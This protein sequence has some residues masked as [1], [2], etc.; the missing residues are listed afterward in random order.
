METLSKGEGGLRLP[1]PFCQS[2]I[3]APDNAETWPNPVMCIFLLANDVV[4][5]LHEGE[6]K[7]HTSTLTRT[8]RF[9]LSYQNGKGFAHDRKM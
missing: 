7:W 8:F 3:L 9:S 4:Q 6:A 5:I 1:N 2:K